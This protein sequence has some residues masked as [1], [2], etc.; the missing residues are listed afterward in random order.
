MYITVMSNDFKVPQ[1]TPGSKTDLKI[2]ILD[3]WLSNF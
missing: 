3:F 2:H 1:R